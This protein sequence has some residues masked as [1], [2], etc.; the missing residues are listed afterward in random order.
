MRRS[1]VLLVLGAL[2]CAGCRVDT[3]AT[4]HLDEVAEVSAPDGGEGGAVGPQGPAGPAGPQGGLPN[5]WEREWRYD[6][7]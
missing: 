2:L 5:L 1:V 3:R 7:A 6:L 4:V